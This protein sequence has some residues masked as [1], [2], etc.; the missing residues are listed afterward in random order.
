M[1]YLLDTNTVIRYINGRTP[2]ILENMR[3][4]PDS[5]IAVCS[6]TKGELF[7]GS[8]KSKQ[9]EISRAKQDAFFGS[10]C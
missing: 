4:I 5:E 6:V 8:F 1:T 9:P 7:T 2:R 3:Q 10:I